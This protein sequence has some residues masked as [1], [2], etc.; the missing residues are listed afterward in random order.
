MRSKL[1]QLLNSPAF[2]G[3]KQLVLG[4]FAVQLLNVCF[5]P[6]ITR[7]YS[8]ESLGAFGVQMN[9]CYLLSII[10]GG[11]YYMAA[12]QEKDDSKVD[13]IVSIS[14]LLSLIFVIITVTAS[15]FFTFSKALP[16][17]IFFY[18][19]TEILKVRSYRQGNLIEAST[20]VFLNRLIAQGFKCIKLLDPTTL[21]LLFSEVLGNLAGMINYLKHGI[22]FNLDSTLKAAKTYVKY[23][24]F[25]MPNTAVGYFIQEFPTFYFANKFGFQTA[26]YF[27]LYQKIVALPLT[28][29]G[30][31]LASSL[32]K[33]TVEFESFHESKLFLRKTIQKILLVSVIPSL[34]I[35]FFAEPIFSI[36]LGKEYA[37]AGKVASILFFIIPF[38]LMKGLGVISTLNSN[39]LGNLTFIKFINLAVL[40][41]FVNFS[42]IQNFSTFLVYFSLI[43]ICFDL[44]SLTLALRK[45]PS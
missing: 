42:Q 32:I 21:A 33:K 3:F 31:I 17:L 6:I 1:T 2:K 25:F 29:F 12:I 16:F 23:P 9:I 44:I 19:C 40:I 27:F 39:K 28:L 18:S 15:F 36:A 7:L 37:E 14:L 5:Y 22:K 35:Y 11:Q 26:A 10:S 13:T 38:K 43:E 8:S 20:S 41:G 24:L 4:N 34:V 30:S 45:E